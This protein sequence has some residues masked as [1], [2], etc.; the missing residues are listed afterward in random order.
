MK[1][2][3]QKEESS[4]LDPNTILVE[5]MRSKPG[6]QL[7]EIE[8]TVAEKPMQLVLIELP[9]EQWLVVTCTEKP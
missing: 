9:T 4:V 5:Q 2:L 7:I 1:V 8:A 3:T 6:G